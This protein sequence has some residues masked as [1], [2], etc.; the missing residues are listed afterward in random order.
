MPVLRE[1]LA[2]VR[3]RPFTARSGYEWAHVEQL[4]FRA[5]Q[6]VVDAAHRL[7]RL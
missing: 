5:E 7:A 2:L 4:A 3:G 6:L 1:G